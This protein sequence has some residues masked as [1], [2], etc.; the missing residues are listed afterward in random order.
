MPKFF[1]KNDQIDNGKVT[2]NGED[3]NHISN[4]LRMKKND[5]I[6]I[7]NIE[8]QENYIANITNISKTEVICNILEKIKSNAESNVEVDIFQGLPKSDKMELIIQKSVELGVKRIIPVEMKRCVVKLDNKDKIKKVE[9]WN[10]IAEVA[11]KQSGR[12]IIPIIDNIKNINEISNKFDEYDLVLLCYENEK[13]VF[14]KT[15]LKQYKNYTHIKIAVIVGPEGGIDISEVM[16]MQQYGAKVI[17]LGSRI[18]RTETVSLAMLS[19]IMYEFE[20]NES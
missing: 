5:L 16:H 20:R 11:A 9:R 17:S 2:I 3:V 19:V 13:E 15:V 1:V 4:V 10:K 12:N 7:C 6:N 14:L 8:T 18:L